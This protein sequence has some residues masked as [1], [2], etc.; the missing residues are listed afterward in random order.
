MLV[1][2]A[3]HLT[4]VMLAASRYKAKVARSGWRS[5]LLERGGDRT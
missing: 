4:W 2:T 5:D 1:I 3:L